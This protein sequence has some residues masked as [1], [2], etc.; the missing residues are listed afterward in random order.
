MLPTRLPSPDEI[1]LKAL[2]TEEARL[3]GLEA[4]KS[5]ISDQ[6][7]NKIEEA[8]SAV[9]HR[10]SELTDRIYAKSTHAV[11]GTIGLEMV[12]ELAI[13]CRH[14]VDSKPDGSM[15]Y[16]GDGSGNQ[17]KGD[18]VDRAA[19]HLIHA[20]LTLAGEST[21]IPT[22]RKADGGADA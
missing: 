6:A 3:Y 22:A 7:Y 4:T 20:V 12:T 9:S 11:A 1:Q 19:A 13:F 16:L 10:I 15:A 5:S 14:W 8:L 18:C 21:I 2:Q 17:R